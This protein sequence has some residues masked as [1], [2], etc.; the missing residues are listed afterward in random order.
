MTPGVYTYTVT[1]IAPC[2]NASA[3]VTVTETSSPNAGTNSSATVC[4]NGAAINLFAQLGDRRMRV[5]HGADQARLSVATTIRPPWP[6]ACTPTRW[7][8]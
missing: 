1:G 2:A 8:R 3:T 7:Q 6:P 4:G 5:E